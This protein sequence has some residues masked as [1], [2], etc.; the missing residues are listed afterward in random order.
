MRITLAAVA[1]AIL[2][3][4][5]AG[6]AD[7]TTRSAKPAFT[8]AQMLAIGP[9]VSA[10]IATH[11]QE[12]MKALEAGASTSLPAERDDW[13]IGSAHGDVT[14]VLFVDR[15]AEGARGAI[16]TVAALA[17]R[18]SG[19]RIVVKEL[20]LLSRGS[21][22][23]AIGAVA[24]RR[25][26][27]ATAKLF[28]LGLIQSKSELGAAAV[29]AAARSAHVDQKRF[30]TDQADMEIKA[31][32]GR[33]RAFADTLGVKGTPTFLVGS[34]AFVGTPNLEALKLAIDHERQR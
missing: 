6:A 20:P 2:A 22:D 1:A 19:V 24:A 14:V 7:V 16:A 18:E 34:Q 21:I 30:K 17:A 10:W 33:V 25:Q 26:G 29:D 8:D 12:I 9:L 4:G 11:P 23:A 32:L 3:A 15:A 28:E 27:E 13:V 5:T 31:Y